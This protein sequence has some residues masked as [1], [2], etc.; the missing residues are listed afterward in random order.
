VLSDRT[1]QIIG[2]DWAVLFGIAIHGA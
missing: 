1:L 2:L